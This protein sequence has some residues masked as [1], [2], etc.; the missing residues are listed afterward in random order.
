MTSNQQL[1]EKETLKSLLAMP[2]VKQRFQEILKDRSAAFTASILSLYNASTQLQEADPRSILQSAMVAA[3]LDLPIT[4]S[5]G[6][7]FIIPY[8]KV[9]QFQVG[10]KGFVELALRTQKYK[11]INVSEVYSDEIAKWNPLTGDFEATPYETW[12]LRNKSDPK[13]IVGYLA[14]FKLLSGFEKSSY[15]TIEQIKLHG[16]KYSKSFDNPN[17]QWLQNFHAMASKTV[18]KLLLS[19]YGLLSIQM[20]KAIEVDQAV[21]ETTGEVSYADRP[22]DEPVPTKPAGAEKVINE[23]QLKLL[24]SRID[25]SGIAKD[26]VK[27]FVQKTFGRDHLKDLTVEELTNVL[28]WLEQ[29]P[30]ADP[31]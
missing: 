7:A 26:E 20:E 15:M 14:Y 13:D 4:P 31:K 22:E 5:L 10:T 30:P 27:G 21:I 8:G 1:Q 23:D 29:E 25:K 16:K 17:G 2:N 6:R 19:K 12:K 9:A 11:S 28:K 3:T 24:Y 18:L